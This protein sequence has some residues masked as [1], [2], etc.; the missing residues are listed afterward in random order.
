MVVRRNLEA[1]E[2]QQLEL[3]PQVIGQHVDGYA[4]VV[5][6]ADVAAEFHAEADVAGFVDV[7]A[8]EVRDGAALVPGLAQRALFRLVHLVPVDAF[9][10]DLRGQFIVAGASDHGGQVGADVLQ[11]PAQR[12]A[13]G[14]LVHVQ[15]DVHVLR[16]VVVVGVL[17]EAVK[18][19]DLRV[20]AVNVAEHLDHEA[21]V[22]HD[23][24]AIGQGHVHRPHVD[25]SVSLFHELASSWNA[26]SC[27]GHG[28]RN[29][30]FGGD[31]ST[32]PVERKNTFQKFGQ[33]GVRRARAPYNWSTPVAL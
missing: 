20:V 11:G 4:A 28:H 17:V 14:G 7:V 25:D 10:L 22:G 26:D 24:L 16:P 23:F 9:H 3:L 5:G 8:A 19:Q 13:D 29:R 6:R 2:S 30:C 33:I 32:V 1:V 21:L 18:P 31:Y 12:S 15:P 27:I